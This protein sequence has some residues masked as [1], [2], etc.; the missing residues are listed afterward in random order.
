MHNS[1]R[2]AFIHI[3]FSKTTD[4]RT[5]IQ[6]SNKDT[7]AYDKGQ[8]VIRTTTGLSAVKKKKSARGTFGA[9]VLYDVVKTPAYSL[10]TER[11]NDLPT[12]NILQNVCACVLVCVCHTLDTTVIEYRGSPLGTHRGRSG[13][14]FLTTD[15]A[16]GL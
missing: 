7:E 10:G 16:R 4:S 2:K 11:L 8:S 1:K 3:C 12:H 6:P 13:G 15:T 5:T 9:P 14:V